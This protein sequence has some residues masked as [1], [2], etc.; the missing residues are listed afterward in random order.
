M[1]PTTGWLIIGG[2][3]L[4]SII[5]G[6]LL[7]RFIRVGKGDRL[8]PNTYTCSCDCGAHGSFFS[9]RRAARWLDRH[10]QLHSGDSL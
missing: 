6:L 1:S 2:W 9:A 4:L 3:L 10:A 5:I 7:G 8:I